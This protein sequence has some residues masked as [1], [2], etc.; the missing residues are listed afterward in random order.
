MKQL[1][2]F[3]VVVM[4]TA[5]QSTDTKTEPEAEKTFRK[6]DITELQDNPVTLFRDNWLVVTAANDTAYNPMTISWGALGNVWQSPAVTIY[7]RDSRYTYQFIN[8]GKYFTLCAF[9]EE[10][11]EKVQF[12]GS[13]S[14][15]NIDKIKE[16]GITPQRTELG[17]VF[18]QEARLVIECEKIYHSDMLP[19]NITDSV[20]QSFYE[21]SDSKHR[22]FIGKIIN[23][24]EKQ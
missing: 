15:R 9:D 22:M 8:S 6:I 19:E 5:C 20:G 18:Y 24:W 7:I 17:N 14:G 10:H 21:N 11:R 13:K 4:I 1:L 3:L 16:T 2:L 12:I 23:V